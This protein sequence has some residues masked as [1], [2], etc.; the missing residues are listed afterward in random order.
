MWPVALDVPSVLQ[1]SRDLQKATNVADLVDALGEALARSTSYRTCWLCTFQPGAREA[2]VIAAGGSYKGDLLSRITTIPIDGDPMVEE[3]VASRLPVIVVDARTDPRTNKEIVARVGNRTIMNFPMLLG[4]ELLGA[5]G[6]GTFA[7]EPP[8]RPTA[9]ELEILTVFATQLAAACQRVRL[10]EA[11]RRLEDDLATARRRESL[12][13]L[14]GGVA[15]DF[16]NLLT[17]IVNGVEF[18][19]TDPLTRRQDEDLRAVSDAAGR[20]ADLTR[21]LLALGRRQP[22]RRAPQELGGRIRALAQLLRRV[23]PAHVEMVVDVPERLAPVHGDGAQLDQVL[24]NLCLNARDAMP[25]GGRLT[26]SARDVEIGPIPR[27][28]PVGPRVVITVADTGTGIPDDV[29]SHVLEPF[30][31]TKPAGQGTGLGLAVAAGIVEQHGGTISFETAPGKGT[32]FS[33]SLPATLPGAPAARPAPE[34]AGRPRGGGERVLVADDE[35]LVR[36]VLRRVLEGAGYRVTAVAD[37]LAAVDA[38]SREPFDLVI[39]DAVMPGASGR[40]AWERIAAIRPGIRFLVVSGY[41]ADTF[42]LEALERAG[43][44]LLG[45]P[46]T[47]HS[48]LGAVRAALDDAPAAAVNGH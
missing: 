28:A 34:H 36:D 46:F 3:I 5:V 19:R 32:R 25:E 12:G 40:V 30:F 8:R 14:A 17:A 35:E 10:V 41:A 48:L 24:M 26:I 1:F 21:R 9:A 6:I 33:I 2:Q 13:I 7:P 11:Q 23:V 22:L 38:A 37:G 29:A 31:T 15:H 42:P 18:V 44:P 47:E 45:K 4:D 39:L 27:G 16:N 43:V 20:A